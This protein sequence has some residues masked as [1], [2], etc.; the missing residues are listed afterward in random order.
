MGFLKKIFGSEKE[1]NSS[2]KRAFSDEEFNTDYELKQKG[3]DDVLGQSNG[4][5]GHAVIPFEVG[6]AVDMYYYDKHIAGTGFV[7]MELLNPAGIGPKTNRIGTYEL[8]A[9]TKQDYNENDSDENQTSFNL[10]ERRICYIFTMIGNYSFQAVL[11]PNETIEIPNNTED[12]YCLI[13]DKYADFK[14]GDRTHHLL[15]CLEV[16]RKEMDFAREYGTDLLIQ[17]L[18]EKGHYPYSDL[19]RKPVI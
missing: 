16:F 18:K 6:G 5:V 13:F 9:F 15:L 3:L 7:T 17:I 4:I 19:D 12:N 1:D 2:A 8:V 14:I 11:N 10:I